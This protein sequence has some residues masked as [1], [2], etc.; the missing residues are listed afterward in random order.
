MAE[1]DNILNTLRSLTNKKPGPNEP[2]VIVE[3]DNTQKFVNAINLLP[4]TSV[5]VGFL[6]DSSEKR[7]DT[8][9]TNAALGYIHETG[10]PINNIPPRPFLRPG[11]IES[12]KAWEPQMVKA[13][14]AAMSGDEEAMMKRFHS[15]GLAAQN[16]I[17]GKIQAGLKPDLSPRTIRARERRAGRPLA[18]NNPLMDTL[19]LINSIHYAIR[20]KKVTT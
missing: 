4:G 9:L 19:Q 15:A 11:A 17:K 12:Q 1:W 2:G 6:D 5:L 14:Q 16:G 13:A 7:T 3:V 18:I 10:S 20:T 8:P